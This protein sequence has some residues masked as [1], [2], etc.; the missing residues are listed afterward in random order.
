MNRIIGRPPGQVAVLY[1]G[2]LAVLLG[3]VGLCTDVGLMYLNWQQLQKAADAAVLAG[4]NYLPGDSSTAVSTATTLA[5]NNSVKAAEIVS[6][7][8]AVSN[9]DSEIT[10]SLQR[11]VPYNFAQVLGLSSGNVEVTAS[12]EVENIGGAEGTPTGSHLIP[13]GFACAS[14]PCTT[15]GEDICLPG[16]TCNT[17]KSPGN[18]GGLQ[19]S[20]GQQYTGSHYS[21]AIENGY[22]GTAPIVLGTSNG[23]L[24]VT[25]NDV[26]NFAPS[27]L[28]DR[29][30]AGSLTPPLP[31]P[32]TASELN[33]PRIV[34]IP[35]VS[36]WPN[37]KSQVL[38]VTGFIT[39]LLVPDGSGAYYGE[40]LGISLGG[41]VGSTSAPS[42]GTTTPVLIQ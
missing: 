37:G 17:M 1:V 14:P 42:T 20:D 10:I 35:M 33:D 11:S 30:N 26:N 25:G 34:E 39:A 40:V 24:P 41:Q 15:V 3:A 12:A 9:S 22:E 31:S 13:V 2:V 16:E 27:G 21:A 5:E 19:Y 36:A 32:L 29:Y 8:P 7:T 28:A 18:W 38:D 6:G 23:I 4:A